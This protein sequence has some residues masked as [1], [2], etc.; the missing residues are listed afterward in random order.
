M[1][2]SVSAAAPTISMS[3]S[4]SISSG[5]GLA[6]DGIVLGDEDA[7]RLVAHLARSALVD[8]SASS[9][10]HTSTVVP[11]PGSLSIR[12]EPSASPIRCRIASS[13]SCPGRGR[14]G[15]EADSVVLD[16]ERVAA[17]ALAQRHRRVRR[18]GVLLDV[19]EQ[20]AADPVQGHARRG[21][22]CRPSS[23]TSR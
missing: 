14:P 5:E 9:G 20:F 6:D 8:G 13:P 19:D 10:I 18:P 4:L 17:V 11:R 12:I 3:G 22:S 1:A 7:K 15:R 21:R 23:S 16:A 2:S